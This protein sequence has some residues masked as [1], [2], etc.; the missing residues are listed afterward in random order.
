MEQL[1]S[2]ALLQLS[3]KEKNPN[4]R[5]RLL[6]ISLFLESQNRSHVA[7]QLKV[8]RRSV[9][10]WVSEYLSKGVSGLD[11]K[12]L[13]GRLI[14]LSPKQEQQL[15]RYIDK[16][17][18]SE[19]GGR[20]TGMDVKHYIA[21]HFGVD[22]HLNH[23]YKVLANLGFSWITSRSRHPKQTQGVQDAYKKV[24]AGN[25]PSHSSTHQT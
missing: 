24:P 15:A 22:Y 7:R 23:I 6:A 18:K 3:K 21:A 2:A 1:S 12:P 20:L 19:K 17:A 8:A 4:K 16:Q 9:N 25:D 5:I 13:K 11:D 14:A 10:H